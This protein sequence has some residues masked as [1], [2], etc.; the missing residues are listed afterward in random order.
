MRDF[1]L[2]VMVRALM[3]IS[4]DCNTRFVVEALA[5]S[6]CYLDS[7]NGGLPPPPSATTPPSKFAADVVDDL[8]QVAT[9]T[10]DDHYAKIHP[11]AGWAGY[12]HSQFGGY[13]NAMSS[14]PSS[15]SNDVASSPLPN[16]VNQPGEE[17]STSYLASL[18]ENAWEE[19]KAADYG[20][21]IR[22]GAQVYLDAI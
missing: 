5:S 13:L 19:G 11:G 22:W 2:Q 4:F 20:N 18:K 17:G 1:L 10:P 3:V 14:S 6:K 7:L 12:K 21:D 16:T 9:I 8:E 15:T